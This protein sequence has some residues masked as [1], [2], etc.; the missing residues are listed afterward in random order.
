MRGSSRTSL[1]A[2]TDSLESVLPKVDGMALSEELFA[3]ADTFSQSAALRRTLTDPS[4][5]A[6]GK[7]NAVERVLTGKV[8]SAAIETTK[9]LVRRRWSEPGDLAEAT[10]A[11][12]I[13]SVLAA[14]E[15]AGGLEAVSEELFRVERLLDAHTQLQQSVSD[16]KFPVE[17][18]LGLISNVFSQKVRPET[19]ALVRQA[20]RHPGR[21]SVAGS[22]K[23]Y[24]EQAA[25]RTERSVAR[26]EAAIPLGPQHI[27]RLRAAL[28]R[29]YGRP[30]HINVDVVPEI[31][32]G[33]RIRVGDEVIDSTVVNQLSGV[34][35]TF[36]D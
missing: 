36:A 31:V 23:A 28:Q 20:V 17:H 19:V 27:D 32:G 18:R 3:I 34:R 14:A 16:E 4:R 6:D 29:I 9:G 25:K 5:D 2:A 15:Q 7:A 30:I 8:S 22:L 33:M 21:R 26:V 10:E 13:T 12:G 35:R 11:L 24:S 1:A